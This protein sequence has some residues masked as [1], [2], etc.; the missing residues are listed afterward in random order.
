MLDETLRRAG[1][2]CDAAECHGAL[3]GLACSEPPVG[4]E[5]WLEQVMMELDPDNLHVTECRDALRHVYLAC[6]ADLDAAQL[7]FQ[8]LLPDD[9]ESLSVRASA[10]GRWCQ[11][12]LFGLSLGGLPELSLLPGE[13]SEI[14]TEMSELTRAGVEE[15]E[16][17][18]QGERAYAELIEFI[19]IS[20]HL[21]REELNA[22]SESQEPAPTVH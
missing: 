1:V 6:R 16:D 18:E 7:P 10:L 11:G 13:V 4:P 14:I 15:N 8:P 22:L 20:V 2:E 5:P 17:E 21:V 19:R 12:F 3:A 9:E